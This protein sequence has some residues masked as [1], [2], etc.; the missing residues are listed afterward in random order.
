MTREA[1]FVGRK[2]A[3][4][5]P[6]LL[7]NLHGTNAV[8]AGE[9]G[10]WFS[11]VPSTPLAGLFVF[12]A[13]NRHLTL[14]PSPRSRRRGWLLRVPGLCWRQVRSLYGKSSDDGRPLITSRVMKLT[15]AGRARFL[16]V[17]RGRNFPTLT[18]IEGLLLSGQLRRVA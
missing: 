14:N 18:T 1:Y 9:G 7:P 5:P 2:H 16:F 4:E 17:W 11:P 12:G 6:A 10:E 13:G 15:Q 3:G 8:L